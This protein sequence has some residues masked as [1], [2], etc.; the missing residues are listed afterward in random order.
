MNEQQRHLWVQSM[1]AC[2]VVNNVMQEM[3]GVV[4]KTSKQHKELTKAR[5]DR[6]MNDTKTL[7]TALKD[8]NLFHQELELK[9]IMTGVCANGHVNVDKAK[10]IGKHILQSMQEESVAVFSFKRKTHAITMA[11]KYVVR[12]MVM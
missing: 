10:D 3:S 11:N 2:I 6:D 5:I 9:N 8:R 1:P 4:Y 7:M 12:L